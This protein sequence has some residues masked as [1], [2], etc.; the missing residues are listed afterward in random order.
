MISV[1]ETTGYDFDAQHI[2]LFMRA[3]DRQE[4]WDIGRRLPW[5]AVVKSLELSTE[6]YIATDTV[7]GEP[8]AVFGAYRDALGDVAVPWLL[9]TR[10]VD[11]NAGA[12]IKLTRKFCAH[13]L[14]SAT[15]LENVALESNRRTLGFLSLA[16]FVMDEPTTLQNGA[17]VVRFWMEKPNV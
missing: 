3:E 9:G 13:L 11:R 17:R 4:L 5:E 8:V 14:R 6:A 1:R 10:G 15:R 2:A 7:A 16:G 12:Y